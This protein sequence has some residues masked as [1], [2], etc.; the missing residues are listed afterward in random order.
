AFDIDANG[1]VHVS[2]KD[3]G[4]GKEQKIQITTS[5]GLSKEEIEKMV[6]DAEQHADTDKKKR[7]II[8]LK[9]QADSLVYQSEKTLKENAEKIPEDEQGAIKEATAA[10]K[11]AMEGEDKDA[12]KTGIEKLTQAFHKASESIYKA[13]DASSQSDQTEG[14]GGK[15]PS[16]GGSQKGSKKDDDDVVDADF[17]EIKD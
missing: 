4:T 13:A 3:L 2:A 11:T 1:I 9:N 5:G 14:E 15:N 16:D 8:D 12:L 10:L 7:E 6:L 17:E